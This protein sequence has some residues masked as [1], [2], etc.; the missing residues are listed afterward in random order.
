MPTDTPTWDDTQPLAAEPTWDNTVPTWD[1]T[2]AIAEPT[3]NKLADAARRIPA[4]VQSG[5][6]RTL[7][8]AVR[9][10]DIAATP[11]FIP[12]MGG[13]G[14]GA[15][16]INRLNQQMP[17]V[18]EEFV[19]GRPQ[20]LA[21]STAYQLGREIEQAAAPT[22]GVDPARDNEFL[23]QLATA[24]G[25]MVPT[26]AAGAVA[27]PAGV[28]FQY[29]TSAGEAQAQEAIAA[30]KPEA[31][32]MAFLSAAGLGGITEAA[33][34][35]PGRLLAIANRA[36]KAGV[37][38]GTFG[39]WANRNPMA[40]GIARAGAE[41]A[42]REGAQ[43]GLEQA[44]QNLIASD[45]AG[46]APAR[47]VTEGVGRAMALGATLGG[48][49][50]GGSAG[51]NQAQRNERAALLRTLRDGRQIIVNE[52]TGTTDF[53]PLEGDELP[54]PPPPAP[55][56]GPANVP[57][58]I[59]GEAAMETRPSASWTP[60]GP[61]TPAVDPEL[62]DAI[63]AIRAGYNPEVDAPTPDPAPPST[64]SLQPSTRGEAAMETRLAAPLGLQREP[65]VSPD[66]ADTIQALRQGYQQQ[67]DV[68]AEARAQSAASSM[69]T[70]SRFR[71]KQ[72]VEFS[73][74]LV[75]PS[76]AS[77]VA[78]EWKW[79][80][81]E[82]VDERGEERI[83][84][85]SNWEE[86]Q[87]SAET[88]RD[89]VHQFQVKLPDGTVRMVSAES[90]PVVLGFAKSGSGAKLPTLVNASKTLAQLKMKLALLE[91]QEASNTEA[92]AKAKALPLP[93]IT[94]EPAVATVGEDAGKP[95]GTRFKMG[96]DSWVL[97]REPGSIT[98]ERLRTLVRS[99]Q[100]ARAKEFGWARPSERR[101]DLEN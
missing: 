42:L 33:L 95:Y 80:P 76:G 15:E 81:V 88:G 29:G 3:S 40:A 26:L 99:W 10:G 83:R 73:Q 47:P 43:E 45:V 65:A 55:P 62:A 101:V 57:P 94:S 24:A 12:F 39:R 34:G 22:F 61:R 82:E 58:P 32:D 44:G 56:A 14:P 52:Q 91:Q 41:G 48:V 67:L 90:V 93:P 18:R 92:M 46:Y 20:R 25:E 5:T 4:G 21:E 11:T 85:I 16:T 51:L 35:V 96:T 98:E 68:P 49:I 89:I 13:L 78:Y 54:P 17:A 31:A 28:A 60:D 8:G 50:G 27:G 36:R 66:L 74:P 71:P 79:T 64:F 77:L 69:A 1:N 63:A 6:G 38:P 19:R 37:N 84:R 9:A 53:P 59:R 86:A 2:Q 100:D 70:P 75:G 72:A 7:A 87:S 23:A 30:G 97:Q